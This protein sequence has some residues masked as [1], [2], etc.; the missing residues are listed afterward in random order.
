M[1]RG[2]LRLHVLPALGGVPLG[3]LS[4]AAVRTWRA[5]LLSAGVPGP[6]TVAKSYR[7]LHAICATAVEDN[8]IAANPCSIKGASVERPAERPVA[9]IEQVFALSN[10]I[11]ERYRAMVLLATFCGLRVGEL[12]ALRRRHLD[13]VARRVAVVEQYQQLSN[14]DLVLGPPKTD[15]GRRSVAIPDVIIPDLRR[16]LDR[17]SGHE[18]DEFV[19]PARAAARSVRRRCTQRGDVPVA[20]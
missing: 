1:Y 9:T 16:H 12:R 15:A 19:F 3:R 4:T 20:K 14:G 7:L 8:L 2:L 11:D 13:L 10:A 17:R 5:G 6:S 18:L